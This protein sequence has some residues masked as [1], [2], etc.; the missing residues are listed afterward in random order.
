MQVKQ[1][2]AWV[3]FGLAGV[4]IVVALAYAVWQNFKKSPSPS[5][6]LNPVASP[7]YFPVPEF[8]PASVVAPAAPAQPPKTNPAASS[9]LPPVAT[10]VQVYPGGWVWNPHWND[11]FHRDY[12]YARRSDDWEWRWGREHGDD[13]RPW[14]RPADPAERRR[15]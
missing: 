4:C 7:P 1:Q 5:S 13:H 10:M 9:G 15:S 8:R 6:P 14:E 3:A 11:R 2:H 12:R